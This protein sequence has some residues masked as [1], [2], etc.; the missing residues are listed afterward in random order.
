MKRQTGPRGSK[1]KKRR[2]TTVPTVTISV[3]V[4]NPNHDDNYCE[5]GKDA[6]AIDHEI[7]GNTKICVGE[8]VEELEPSIKGSISPIQPLIVAAT[9]AHTIISS[10]KEQ[11]YSLLDTQQ[12]YIH[13]RHLLE[14]HSSTSSVSSS[15]LSSVLPSPS[16]IAGIDNKF[17]NI[18][19]SK[20]R[21]LLQQRTSN[22]TS[23]S[24][25]A[26]SSSLFW[27]Q[28]LFSNLDNANCR[29]RTTGIS[30][31]Q[32]STSSN[33]SSHTEQDNLPQQPSVY[34]PILGWIRFSPSCSS[35]D[36]REETSVRRIYC[37]FHQ[38]DGILVKRSLLAFPTVNSV[39]SFGITLI[40]KNDEK[41]TT[42]T[43]TT[44]AE[45]ASQHHQDGKHDT[46]NHTS[47]NKIE[48]GTA[49]VTRTIQIISNRGATIRTEYDIDA[50][51]SIK[52]GTL[53]IGAT[54]E[55]VEKVLLLPA[56]NDTC[57]DEDDRLIGV[58]R[59]KIKLHEC[60]IQLEDHDDKQGGGKYTEVIDLVDHDHDDEDEDD[61]IDVS[62]IGRIDRSRTSGRTGETSQLH[63]FSYGWI[64]DRGRFAKDMYPILRVVITEKEQ[65]CP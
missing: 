12:Q 13:M 35:S 29:D 2:P 52:I 6:V 26:S 7:S 33:D 38:G 44:T 34:H 49:A 5:A 17:I 31:K 39:S 23:S 65:R 51:S 25:S 62:N 3:K 56:N 16:S 41:R 40:D 4:S 22:N 46:D 36:D 18:M 54:R 58:W 57:V 21:S 27:L 15:S 64:S 45:A 11:S 24:S 43:S 61:N 60:D 42:I 30:T 50:E 8:S 37:S 9:R 1:L 48:E 47:M 14:A 59:Y 20:K 63:K 55:Y 19:N 53:A 28:G 10:A 32:T